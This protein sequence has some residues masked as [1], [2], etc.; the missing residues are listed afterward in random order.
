MG[1][2]A[3]GSKARSGSYFF[4][5]PDEVVATCDEKYIMMIAML[6]NGLMTLTRQRRDTH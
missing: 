1:I 3:S 5:S 4:I 2:L 6:A